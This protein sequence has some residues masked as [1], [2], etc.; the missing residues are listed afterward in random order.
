MFTP[1]KPWL[2]TAPL[3]LGTIAALAQ[4]PAPVGSPAAATP[5]PSSAGI[6]PLA[7]VH[8]GQHGTAYTVFEGTVP[9]P[10]GVDIL[11]VL[12]NAQGPG[13]D[14]I[15]ARLTGAKAEYTGVVAGMSGSP[16]YI[17]GKLVGAVAFRIGEFAKEPIAGITPIEQMLPVRDLDAANS[18][19]TTGNAAA[20]AE[21]GSSAADA[22]DSG[23]NNV[24]SESDATE[25]SDQQ[26]SAPDASQIHPIETPLVFTGFSAEAV[27]LWRQHASGLGMQPVAG[28]G[29]G[30]G[31]SPVDAPPLEPG[32]AVSALLVSGDM[33][34]A[35]TCTVTYLDAAHLLACGHPLTQF[36]AVSLP[37]TSAEVITT[38][39]SPAGSFKIVN[40]GQIVGAFTQDRQTAIGG[41]L[42]ATARMIPV[43][44]A[45]ADA[46]GGKRTLRVRVLDQAQVTP[47]AILVSLFQALQQTP[48]YA[49][50]ASYHVHATVR[51]AGYQPVEIDTLAAPGGLGPAALV[52]ALTVG[53]RFNALYSSSARHTPVSSVDISVET[54]GGRRSTALSRAMLEQASG[55]ATNHAPNTAH[56]GDRL[57]VAATLAP[58]RSNAQTVRIPFTLPASLSA[59][60]VRV[61]VSDGPTLDRLMAAGR[62]AGATPLA[63]T[64]AQLNAMHAD[65]RLYVTLL[66]PD[67]EASIDGQVL[68]SVPP[69]VLNLVGPSHERERGALHSESLEPLGSVSVEASFTGEQILTIRVE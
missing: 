11:G 52:A 38:L 48:G 27:D 37:M 22:P 62:T 40:T 1:R 66:R 43:T 31:A 58:Y 2:L 17:D 4:S 49:E 51:L 53:T 41:L 26:S 3:L 45:L 50:E 33:E 36:G 60:D 39:A 25:H 12:H 29:G 46:Q 68:S 57:A 19:T 61:L 35:A 23:R 16:V 13:E 69:S 7:S 30:S 28:L 20:G 65:N 5:P 64:V 55:Q 6:Y 21:P 14:L 8:A 54:L 24:A 18:Q 56:A 42:G 63:S 10:F 44:I 34:I 9:V 59:G 15:L 47:T 32:S 67:A